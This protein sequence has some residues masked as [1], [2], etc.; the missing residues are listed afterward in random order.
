[1]TTTTGAT[2]TAQREIT[3]LQ[4]VNEALH[5]EMERDSKVFV[6]GIDL[7]ARGDVFGTT[8]GI[9]SRFGSERILDTPISENAIVGL[10]VGSALQGLRP[11]VSVMFIDFIGVCFDVILNQMAKNKYMFGGKA[12]LPL[13]VL[14]NAGAGGGMAAQHSQSLE[15]LLCHIP[16]L[17]VVMPSMAAD[18]KGLLTSAIRED[19]PV[20]FV[21]HKRCARLRGH[22]PE[23]EY[24]VPL[25][26]ARVVREGRDATVVATAYMVHEALAAAERLAERG[27][28][29]EIVDPR[30]LQPLDI[31]TILASV[32]KTHRVLTVHEAVQFGGIGAEITSQIVAEAFDHLDAPPARLGGPWSP[33]PYSVVLEREWIVNAD[34]IHDAVVALVEGGEG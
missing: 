22:V 21:Q 12:R 30:T 13:V 26:K 25:G 18:A 14:A 7:A 33:V 9:L 8:R 19:N 20:F 32:Q 17:K 16:G 11:V 10:A 3:Y 24:V 27:I 34:K 2:A 6:A 31:E 5:H 15:A 28:E 23:G 4:A 29:I 1:M